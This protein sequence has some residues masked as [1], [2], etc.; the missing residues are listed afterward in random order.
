ML[1]YLLVLFILLANPVILHLK[2][3]TQ[4]HY[5]RYEVRVMD[6]SGV[7]DI[8]PTDLE[9]LDLDLRDDRIYEFTI[10]G[11]TNGSWDTLMFMRWHSGSKVLRIK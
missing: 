2:W 1:R 8:Y 9:E 7:L 10:E 11:Y 5:D 4:A 6:D 3:T